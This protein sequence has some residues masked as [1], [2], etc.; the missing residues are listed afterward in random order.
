MRKR[1]WAVAAGLALT[2][3]WMSAGEPFA[4]ID[5]L[6]FLTINSGVMATALNY[7]DPGATWLFGGA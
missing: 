1:C 6:G 3:L 5:R 4:N 7:P 2:I